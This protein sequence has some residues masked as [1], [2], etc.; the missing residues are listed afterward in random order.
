MCMD[1]RLINKI[2]IKYRFPIPRLNDMLD[3]LYG[4][5]VFSKVDLRSGYHQIIIYEGDEWKTAF[6]TKEGLYEWLVMP[7]GLSNAPSTFMRLMNQGIQVNE[8]KVQ[9]IRD[10]P[11]PRAIQQNSQAHTAFKELKKQLASTPILDLLCFDEVFKVECDASGVGIGVVL[12]QLGRPIAY[13]SEKLNETKQRYSTYDKEFYAIVRAL[14]QRQHYLISKEFIL[15]SDHEALKLDMSTAY[16][17]KTD[18]QS[19]RTI[20]TLEDMLRACTINFGKGWVNHLTLVEFSYNNSYHASI[21]AAPFEAL[22]GRKCRL[23][24]CW[25]EVGEAQILGPELIQEMTEKIVQI[26][27]RMQAAVIDRRVTLT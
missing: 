25:T 10:W 18:G 22:Y 24:V 4:A 21:K 14:D 5:T 15:H 16:H 23:P 6:K 19:E 9:A 7:F 20:Q 17:S 8:R 13:F 11:V 27:Q 26:K 3:K 12:S 1:S 2:T